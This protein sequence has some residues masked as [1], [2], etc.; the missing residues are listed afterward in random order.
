MKKN[1]DTAILKAIM[2]LLIAVV[3]VTLLACFVM[4]GC[5]TTLVLAGIFIGCNVLIFIFATVFDWCNEIEKKRG[6]ED[7]A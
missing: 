4:Y 3:V 5:F 7:E 1:R 6:G 2:S